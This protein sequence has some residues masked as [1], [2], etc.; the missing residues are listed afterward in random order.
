MSAILHFEDI[1]PNILETSITAFKNGFRDIA[2]A[3]LLNLAFSLNQ[4]NELIKKSILEL[5]DNP[6][7]S[8]S[9]D[10]YDFHENMQHVQEVV[11]HLLHLS[12]KNSLD[13]D[14]FVQFQNLSDDILTNLIVFQNEVSAKSSEQRFN[15]AS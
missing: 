6:E 15:L 12:K 5:E 1:F 10:T 9:L 7:I 14:V 2:D 13:S 3:L 11:E 4:Q 8:L